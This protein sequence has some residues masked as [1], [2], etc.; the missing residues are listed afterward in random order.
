MYDDLTLYNTV[1]TLRAIDYKGAFFLKF[2]DHLVVKMRWRK[3]GVWPCSV[4]S[5]IAMGYAVQVTSQD[6][7]VPDRLEITQKGWDF[8][9]ANKKVLNGHKVCSRS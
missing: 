9:K 1:L 3:H 2:C 4:R 5:V 6:R 8:Y 7:R